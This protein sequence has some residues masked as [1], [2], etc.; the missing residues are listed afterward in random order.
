MGATGAAAG[1]LRRDGSRGLGDRQIRAGDSLRDRV[2]ARG[3]RRRPRIFPDAHRRRVHG[4]GRPHRRVSDDIREYKQTQANGADVQRPSSAAAV[5]VQ[6]RHRTE[7]VLPRPRRRTP[8]TPG[9]TG[10]HRTPRRDRPVTGFHIQ[11]HKTPTDMET[12][13]QPGGGAIS[14]NGT[15]RTARPQLALPNARVRHGGLLGVRQVS[16]LAAN[17][18]LVHHGIRH[19]TD[20]SRHRH[21]RVAASARGGG[22]QLGAQRRLGKAR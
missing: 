18:E 4:R 21:G 16:V 7:A 2:R 22:D 14:T 8:P 5:G 20:A 12:E 19:A 9:G 17:G 13:S 10:R 6:A 3:R 1:R 15:N 11:I